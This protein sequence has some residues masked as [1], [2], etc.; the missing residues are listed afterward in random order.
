MFE[1]RVFTTD[2]TLVGGINSANI[3]GVKAEYKP[4]MAYDSAEHVFEIIITVAAP[5]ALALIKDLLVERLK[6][7]VPK[8]LVIHNQVVNNAE[9]VVI[10]FQNI[11]DKQRDNKL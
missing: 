5:V 1:I 2:Q 11:I 7:E 3:E 9:G 6:K 8:Q 10:I 4:T